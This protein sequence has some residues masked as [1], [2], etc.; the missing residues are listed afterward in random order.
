MM[1]MLIPAPT[2]F[3][4]PLS[5]GGDL[6]IDFQQVDP[7]TKSPVAYGGGITLTLIIDA[8][9]PI[10]ALATIS[11]ADATVQIESSVCDT[12]K[13][14]TPFRLIER[15]PGSPATNTVVLYGNVTRFDG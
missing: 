10:T 8:N 2:S 5:L 14:G 13:A 11:V 15:V 1:A 9:T 12:I 4:L 6:V 3:S 7:V